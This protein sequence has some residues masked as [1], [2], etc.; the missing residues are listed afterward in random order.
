MFIIGIIDVIYYKLIQKNIINKFLFYMVEN[1]NLFIIN[2]IK[3]I[4]NRL[5]KILL[6]ILL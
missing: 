3:K 2:T 5:E 6:F 4:I 1:K